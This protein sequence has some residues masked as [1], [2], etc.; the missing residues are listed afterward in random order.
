LINANATLQKDFDLVVVLYTNFIKQTGGGKKQCA[1]F[2]QLQH[3]LPQR[4][5][6]LRI[7]III[8]QNTTNVQILRKKCLSI[9]ARHEAMSPVCRAAMF[10]TNT[11]KDGKA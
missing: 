5:M 3:C 2:V 6:T 9:S 8:M 7:I 1:N 11:R 10:L 4:Q